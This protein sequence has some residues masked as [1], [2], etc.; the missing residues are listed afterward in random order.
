MNYTNK[1][2]GIWG[3][4]RVGKAAAQFLQ[5]L[6]ASILIYDKKPIIEP[7]SMRVVTSLDQ[8]FQADYLLP[9]PGIDTREYRTQY[10]GTWLSE[11]DLFR[12]YFH[13]PIIAITGSVG[14]T[15]VTHLVTQ[16][17]TVAGWRVHAVGNIGIPCLQIIEQQHE[18]DAV[19]LEVSSFQL[20]Y[21][22]S[23][24]PDLAIWTNFYPNHLDRHGCM[25][26]YFDAKY[27]II[28]YQTAQQSALLPVE[29]SRR[30]C[31]L[32]TKSTLSFFSPVHTDFDYSIFFIDKQEI[33]LHAR[34]STT[35]I[36]PLN[37]L[38]QSVFPIN[39]LITY[40]ALHLLKISPQPLTSI[41]PIAHRLERV[42]RM[43]GVT[44]YNDSKST[45]PASTQAAL[46]AINASRTILFLGGLSKGI[47]RT[48][49]I[50]A[51]QHIAV[52]VICFGKEAVPLHQQCTVM[53]IPSCAFNT[54]SEA[55]H[56]C[57]T[58]SKP[59]DCVLFSPAGSS[60]DLFEN[61]EKRGDEF[62]ALVLRYCQTNSIS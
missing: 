49:L 52:Q 47:D 13:K 7:R 2:V 36:M 48:E 20:E 9:S 28:K 32:P 5:K 34:G 42:A 39:W 35:P 18:L 23:F 14:K 26:D 1:T 55:F 29:L 27:N 53:Q 41:N 56:F 3:Y 33:R 21:I 11:L 40:A 16:A 24:A 25:Q 19:V 15:T 6:G 46:A 12:E 50:Q 54:L 17:L 59:N 43:N 22:K 38:D 37:K 58:I 10:Q 8:L 51:L 57:T 30:M 4:G 31:A 44:F 60:F 61:Y 62:R 45:T